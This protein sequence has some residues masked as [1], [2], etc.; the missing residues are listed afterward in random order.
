MLPTNPSWESR[1]TQDNL[2]RVHNQPIPYKLLFTGRCFLCLLGVC[3][4][5]ATL[6]VLCNRSKQF[7]TDRP[8]LPARE[9]SC[10]LSE[11][12]IPGHFETENPET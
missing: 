3:V 4:D 8:C 2:K 1:V 5:H 9:P 10:F 12:S 7:T 11:W 6:K